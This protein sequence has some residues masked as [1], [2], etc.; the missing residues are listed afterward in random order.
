MNNNFQAHR[1]SAA[2]LALRRSLLDNVLVVL[3]LLA[4]TCVAWSGAFVFTDNNPGNPN[5]APDPNLIV[6]PSDYTGAGG[7]VTVQICIATSSESQAELMIPA[8]NVANTWNRLEPATGNLKFGADNNVPQSEFDVESVLLHEVGHCLGLNH[9]NL[10]DESGL[11]DPDRNYTKAQI[12]PDAAFNLNAGGDGVIGSADDN[13]GDDINLHWFRISDN[14]PFML[15]PVV[16]A[17]TYN[18]N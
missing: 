9:S 13:R 4:V 17:T 2:G 5:P 16:D 15:G 8:A 14:N 7:T 10:V 11:V 1:H 12:G 18:A 3:L 6:H